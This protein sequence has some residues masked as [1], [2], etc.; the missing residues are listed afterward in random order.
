MERLPRTWYSY[1]GQFRYES[2]LYNLMEVIVKNYQFY[3]CDI[4]IIEGLYRDK[5]TGE[6]S[7]NSYT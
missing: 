7:G 5:I 1:Y 2:I 4:E 3:N 6:V